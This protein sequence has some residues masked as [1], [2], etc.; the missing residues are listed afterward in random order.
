MISSV[1]ACTANFYLGQESGNLIVIRIWSHIKYFFADSKNIH[2]VNIVNT[3]L[4]YQSH[5]KNSGQTQ[6]CHYALSMY[7]KTFIECLK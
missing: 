2:T 4:I 3:I 6:G 7:C 1:S 5:L